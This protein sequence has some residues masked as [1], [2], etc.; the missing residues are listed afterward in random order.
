MKHKKMEYFDIK[1]WL[2]KLS[3]EDLIYLCARNPIPWFAHHDND[4]RAILRYLEE[5]DYESLNKGWNFLKSL[6]K[7]RGLLD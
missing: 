1:E 7:N 2:N 5:L 3:Y 6:Y 4:K